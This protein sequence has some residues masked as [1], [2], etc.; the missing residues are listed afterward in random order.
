MNSEVLIDVIVPIYGVE[1]YLRRCIESL[2]NQTY[3]DYIITLVDDGSPDRCPAICD[4]Y[5]TLY[6]QKIRVYHK[7]NGGLSDARNYGVER[8]NSEFVI[9]VDSDDWVSENYIY[10]L[11]KGLTSNEI[12]MVVSPY[13]R[14]TETSTGM[15]I[16]LSMPV[17]AS[18]VMSAE[19]ALIG[20]CKEKYYGSH[21]WS[22]LI[23]RSLVQTYPY[24]IN[25]YYEDCYTT[26]KH[27]ANSRKVSYISIPGYYYFQRNGSIIRSKFLK[28][29]L[30]FVYAN[31]DMV[32]YL[33][34]NHYSDRIISF[35][36]YKLIR[37]AH[38][39]FIHAKNEADFDEIYREVVAVL[40][41]YK[42][43]FSFIE[44]PFKEKMIQN[45]MMSNGFIYHIVLRYTKK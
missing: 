15:S 41:Q 25:K 14:A 39:I 5:A 29:H 34:N 43:Y 36:V 3:T 32:E 2:L 4:E 8:S 40:N 24:P 9:F 11:V 44:Q 27:I 26:Y 13:Y 16:C 42:R 21:A 6:P 7:K 28:K 45:L 1:L 22:K 19:D 30:D 38:A 20:L 23:R 18:R 12:D 33:I 10:N 35:G 31:R 37:S 17:M